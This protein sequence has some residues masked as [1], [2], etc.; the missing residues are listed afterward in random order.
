[1]N[2]IS[3]S[4]GADS[5]AVLVYCRENNIPYEEVVYSVDWFPYPGNYMKDYFRYIEKEFK[6]KITWLEN[7]IHGVRSL[8][9]HVCYKCGYLRWKPK[10][11]QQLFLEAFL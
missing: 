4:G 7:D 9:C 6:I 10:D 1:M 5:T 3:Y 8:G 2:I 11:E